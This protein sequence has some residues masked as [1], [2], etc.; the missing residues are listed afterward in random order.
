MLTHPLL[1]V[2][3][4]ICGAYP[5]ISGVIWQSCVFSWSFVE[6][7]FDFCMSNS[8]NSDFFIFGQMHSKLTKNNPKTLDKAIL[9][10]N[11]KEISLSDESGIFSNFPEN[12][13]EPQTQADSTT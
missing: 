1:P 11:L 5:A 13:E 7:V 12:Q 9:K 2:P 8:R 3:P 10:D 4:E 6:L